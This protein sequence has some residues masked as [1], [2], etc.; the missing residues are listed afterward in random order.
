M[1][2]YT[3]VQ[4]WGNHILVREIDNGEQ[5][6]KRVKYE[7]TLYVPVAKQT[8]YKSLDGKYL[9]PI[10]QLS[11]K[12]AKEFVEQY[13]DQPHLVY[14]NTQ[15]AYTYLSD[16][17]PNE[18][19]W[20][21]KQLLLYTIDIEVQ[22]EN[23]FPNPQQA[24]E[25]MLSITV[26][27]HKNQHIVVWG[28]GEFKTDREDV[29]YINCKD[30]KEL[31]EEF[32]LFW[33]QTT[34]DIVT[35]WNVDFFDIPYLMNRI[36]LLFG[37]DKIKC[38]SPWG[39]VTSQEKLIMGRKNQMYDIM[40][41]SILDYLELYRKFTYTNQENYRLDHIAFVEL[42]E[43]KDENPH[44]TF[45]D[46][47][48]KDYQSFIDYNISDVELVDKLENKLKLIELITTMAYDFKVNYTDMLGTVKYWDNLI[49]NY[50]RQKNIV[51][52]QKTKHEKS[53]RYEGAYVK[54][55]QIGL[56]KW[57]LSFDLN[58]LYPHLIMQYNISPETLLKNKKVDGVNV[59][60]FLEKEFDT[61]FLNNQTI[62]PNGAVYRTDVKGFL[63]E[64]MEKIYNDRVIYKKKALDAQ[65]QYEKTKDKKFLTLN[66][67]YNTKQM[68]QK[69]S[70]NSAYGAIG[71]EWFRYYD[72]LNAEAITTSGQL[73]IR[74]I[75]NKVNEYLNN[76]LKTKNEDYILAVDT[77][78]IYITLDKLVSKLFPDQTDTKKIIDFLDK[79]ATQQIEPFIEKSYQELANYT[80]AYSQKMVMKREVIADKGIWTAKKRYIL[81]VWDSEGVTY[82]EPKLKIMGIE[83]VKSST[84][85]SCRTKIKEALKLMMTG[86]EK[87]INDFIQNFREQFLKL[88]PEDIAYPRS[89]NGV[90]KF[91]DS[92]SMFKK[93]TPIHVKGSILY[94]H[95]LKE[96]R[97]QNKY[98][99]IQEGDKIKFI[100]LRQPNFYQSNVISFFTKL[101]KEFDM[102]ALLDYDTQF[103]KAFVEPLAFIT[104]KI[105]WTIDRSY[106]TQLTLDEFF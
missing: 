56:H 102:K 74:W 99:L 63:P 76:I 67:R 45:K 11:I 6:T 17:Y 43:R 77:D 41:V 25:P 88:S 95:L 68:A 32:M 83:A 1:K 13:K 23:G 49:Y 34:P 71:N 87:D 62:T 86:T 30:E 75:E 48:T 100:Q 36:K 92:T 4:Q 91:T 9:S 55:P 40:G 5:K 101:P 19:Q 52:P 28:L 104:N 84:P 61:S 89:V 105:G 14:G 53:Y 80:N 22:C 97:L 50:L 31:L 10:K 2:F 16:T 26:K 12:D 21:I 44:E 18:I 7:P 90:K 65:R 79:A 38:F 15:F 54:E 69:I 93:G 96:K 8:P 73:A 70:L 33:Q 57:V 82:S 47:Y 35:G 60:K 103:E 64:L 94:N 37:E 51:I 42:G 20:D 106:G 46:W 24:I 3:H 98:P 39:N 29:H 72:I 81:N 66:S 85:A 78:S 59:D 27:N 58:S